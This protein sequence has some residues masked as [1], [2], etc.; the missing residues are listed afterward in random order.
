M[1][2]VLQ[3]FILISYSLDREEMKG[4]IADDDEEEGGSDDGSAGSESDGGRRKKKKR[5]RRSRSRSRS[6]EDL[7][8]DDM[9]LLQ[10]NLGVK[11]KKTRKRI[12]MG[13]GSEDDETEEGH[14][15]ENDELPDLDRRPAEEEGDGYESEDVN[16]FIVD[17]DG[18]PIKRDRKKK[19]QHI[20]ADSA[21]QAAEDI[22]G[23]AFDYDEFEQYGE[24]DYDSEDDDEEEE[25]EEEESER[26]RKK[27]GRKKKST[28]TIFDI[29]EP[30]E[31]ERRH[32]TD[33]DNEIRNTDIPERMQLRSV[34]VTPV[35]EGSDELE[36]EASFIYRHEF[37]KPTVSQQE[38]HTKDVCH[39]WQRKHG[40][41]EQIKLTLDFIRQQLHEVP[42]IASYRK[43]YVPDLKAPELWRVYKAD[44]LWCKLMARK[45]N[46]RKLVEKMQRYQGD[47][48]MQNTNAPLPEGFRQITQ[49]D[50]SRIENAETFEELKDYDQHFKLYYGKDLEAMQEALRQKRKDEREARKLK[51]KLKK[52]KTKIITNEDGEEIEV[53]DEEAQSDNDL[54]NEDDDVDEDDMD[55]DVLKQAK[56]NDP[57][58]IG[59][60]HGLLEMAKRFGLTPE[61]FAENLRDGYQKVEVTQDPSEPLEAAAEYVTDKFP[62]PEEVLRAAEFMVAM[63]IAREPLV[64][65]VT[66]EA[67][68][69]RATVDVNPTKRGVKEIDENHDCYTMKYLKN[70]PIRDLKGDHWLKLMQA[71]EQKLLEIKL[72]EN[73]Y[74]LG[75]SQTFLSEAQELFKHDAFSKSVQDWNKHRGM[76]V[77]I[78]FKNMLYPM[79][80][81]ELRLKLIREAKEGILLA[82][83]QKLRDWIK[84]AKYTVTFEDEDE[85]DWDSSHGCRVMGIMYENDKDV[86]AYGVSVSADGEVGDFLKLEHLLKRKNGWNEKEREEKLSDMKLLRSFIKKKRPHCIV[87]G[88]SDRAAINIQR[89][90]EEEVRHLV[91]GEDQFP[92]IGVYLVDDNLAKVFANS[93]R[94]QQDFRDFPNVLKQAV[95]LAR[96][97]Q[98]PLTEFSQLTG[99]DNEILCLRYHPMQD[100]LSEEELLDGLYIEFITCTNKVGVDI[101]ECV[102]HPFMSNLVQFVG[103]LGPRKGAALLKTLRQ[104]QSS[105]RLEN[106]QQLVTL[107]HMGPKVLINCAGF[108]KIDT[109]SLGDSEVYVEVLDGSRIHNEAYEWARK[110]A[111]D[112]LEYDEEDGNPANALEEILQDP[113]KLSE[114]D[115]DAFAQELE[116]QGFGKKSITLQ[117]IRAELHHMYKDLREPYNPPNFEEVFNM[118]TKETHH[119]FYVGK[120]VQAMVTDF[121]YKKPQGDELDQAAPLRKG[122]GNLWQC[123][124]CG[125]DDFPELT[126]VWNHFDA[127]TCPG[128]AV[129]VKVR[130]DNGVSGFIPI[131]NLSDSNVINPEERVRVGQN[132]FCRITK[133]QP[134]RFS[135]ECICKSSALID[136][137]YE[138]KPIKDEYYDHDSET[139][140]QEKEEEKKKQKQ[141]QAYIKRVIVHPN[142]YNIGFKEAERLMSGMEQG[143]VVIRPSSKGEDRLTVTWKVADGIC[144]HIDVKE[145]GKINAFSLGKSL[146]IGTDEFEDLDEI[147]ARHIN[148]MASHA[149]EVLNFKYYKDTEGGNRDKAK[150]ILQQEKRAHPGKIHYFLSA[151]KEFPGKFMLSYMPRNSSHHEFATVTPE[152]YRF[153]RQ[154]FDTLS[155]LLKWFKEHFRDAIPGTPVTPGRLTNRTPYNMTG[156]PVITP[157]AM[158]MATGT[159]YGTVYNATVNTPYTPSGQTP[160]MTPYQN[161]ATPRGGYRGGLTPGRQPPLPRQGMPPPPPAG[162]PGGGFTP[163]GGFTPGRTTPQGGRTRPGPYPSPYMRQSPA[164]TAQ[165]SSRAPDNWQAAADNWARGGRNAT[166]RGFTGST[167]P[168]R[169]PRTEDQR[170][171]DTSGENRTPKAFSDAT[172]LYDE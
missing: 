91:E 70:K 101:N 43:E 59:K 116:R 25:D 22:F 60:K 97:M 152:G 58:T 68:V 117:D 169:T 153:R 34:P 132:I 38:E 158:S 12:R 155:S 14:V 87:I 96:R 66:R 64:R 148:P 172:P 11:I 94:A 13:S 75:S 168:Q 29:Y 19:K 157:G 5:R 125:Q 3:T 20:F 137:D 147:I 7:D 61:N 83:K 40:V 131:K 105:Q 139:K 71:E 81:K 73:F 124:F 65:K 136:K 69:E 129:G 141:R 10:E 108:I 72:G 15:R 24:D 2:I 133:I 90:V 162:A 32:F 128:K 21:R 1:S 92:K 8:E 142:F 4:F 171:K 55:G 165:G 78:A 76:S 49:E 57:Y 51:K 140:D 93:Q 54:D 42:F 37:I 103:G 6:D 74:A 30:H 62:T 99:P 23:V 31:L 56:R 123:P 149:R 100:V 88:V 111:V 112:A 114:L 161:A 77:E 50:L 67:F 113:E 104:M 159:P 36:K 52:K 27:R 63:Q 28:K 170:K 98:D 80:R 160:F 120:L 150:E 18:Q 84:T 48:I 166:P 127:G 9:E 146:W 46:L 41:Q 151:S 86:A 26:Q 85:D 156:T 107:C 106:R 47:I 44:E 33:L 17:E 167:T 138:Y 35:E 102:A 122:E 163:V 164:A 45:K 95:S 89:D 82:C 110:M 135:V 39:E 16:D 119:T 130:L 144:Q 79:L 154:S 134:D 118:V 126:E 145:K 121:A 109:S 53:T 115:L 143:D